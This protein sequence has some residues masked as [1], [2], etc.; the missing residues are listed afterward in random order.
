MLVRTNGH[1]TRH[2]SATLSASLNTI[3]GGFG[4]GIRS[5]STHEMAHP[6]RPTSSPGSPPPFCTS[7]WTV[8]ASGAGRRHL[9]RDCTRKALLEIENA[10]PFRSHRNAHHACVE[11]ANLLKPRRT[12][13]V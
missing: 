11:F 3:C 12:L 7:V 5:T 9:A 10:D 4:P 6:H 1:A 2:S 8:R 13:L